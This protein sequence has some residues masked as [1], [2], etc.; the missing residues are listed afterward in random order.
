MGNPPGLAEELR[1]ALARLS[2]Y[3]MHW[4]SREP[5]SRLSPSLTKASAAFA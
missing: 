3:T 5:K 2:R 1:R 4:R